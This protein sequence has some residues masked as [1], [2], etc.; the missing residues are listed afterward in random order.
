MFGA[1]IGYVQKFQGPQWLKYVIL[2]QNE[3]VLRA[4]SE[5]PPSKTPDVDADGAGGTESKN[6]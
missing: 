4:C 1:N 2:L 6:S 5:P 3:A